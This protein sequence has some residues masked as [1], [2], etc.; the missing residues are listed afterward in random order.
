ME[1]NTAFENK[2]LQGLTLKN[3]IWVAGILATLIIAAVGYVSTIKKDISDIATAVT[4]MKTEKK[5]ESKFTDLQFKILEQ[6]VDA[7]GLT[8]KE[9]ERKYQ[10]ILEAQINK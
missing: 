10:M 2:V 9:L 4:E 3:L 5:G 1:Q 6:K 8:M 7:Q